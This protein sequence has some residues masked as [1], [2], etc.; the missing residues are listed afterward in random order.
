[1]RDGQ[2]VCICS[3]ITASTVRNFGFFVLFN[4]PDDYVISKGRF[5][6]C[7]GN[8]MPRFRDELAKIERKVETA[9]KDATWSK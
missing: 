5:A 9:V 3:S 8:N 7:F 2:I 4:E 1:M 6:F